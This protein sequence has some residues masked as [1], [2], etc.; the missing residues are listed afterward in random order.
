M[1][2]RHWGALLAAACAV[3]G[4]LGCGSGDDANSE[5]DAAGTDTETDV[6]ADG[7]GDGGDTDTGDD[8]IT[9][10]VAAADWSGT[11][12]GVY[13][14]DPETYEVTDLGVATGTDAV[15]RCQGEN[16][17]VLDRYFPTPPDATENR[18]VHLAGPDL[19]VQGELALGLYANLHGA[20]MYGTHVYVTAFGSGMLDRVD[21][22]TE[23]Y[24]LAETID[25]TAFAAGK[26]DDGNPDPGP[27]AIA[28]DRLF[29]GLGHEKEYKATPFATIAV[30]DPVNGSLVDMDDG[31]NGVQGIEVEGTHI[32]DNALVV[33]GARLLFNASG[34]SSWAGGYDD[35]A[36]DAVD[37]A[38]GQ[39]LGPLVTE[40]EAS[41][42]IFS[43]TFVADDRL[44]AVVNRPD[45]GDGAS[46]AL[47]DIDLAADP[48]SVTVVHEAA[49]DS[50]WHLAA[51]PGGDKVFLADR[52]ADAETLR[53]FDTAS[54]SPIT[55]IELP[56]PANSQC[57]VGQ[58]I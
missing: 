43:W 42:N 3:G 27:V 45:T 8:R 14:V 39:D 47:V 55:E 38:S 52:T 30:Y 46:D 13:A 15:V 5:A 25:L 7:G 20:V 40:T 54:R 19:A 22:T 41:G 56:A 6:G 31:L 29:V 17:F 1:T 57:F 4:P 51:T 28:G 23:P 16:A 2:Q 44:W 37:L 36:I 34:D 48:P 12:G 35:G 21:T 9:L 24:G 58:A 11:G 10:V 26:D 32:F 50:L 18:L 33:R 53:V 49:A